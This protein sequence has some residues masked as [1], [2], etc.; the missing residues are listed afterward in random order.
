MFRKYPLFTL[1][2]LL[3]TWI[4]A[5]SQTSPKDEIVAS[6]AKL[7]GLKTYRVKITMVPGPQMEQQMQVAKQMGWDINMKPMVKEVVNPD[8]QRTTMQIMYPSMDLNMS[9]KSPKDTNG[10][11]F[12]MLYPNFV[13]VL[14]G[15]KAAS[16]IDCPECEKRMDE[17]QAEMLKQQAQ[18]MA[19]TMTMDLVRSAAEAAFMGNPIDLIRTIMTTAEQ[20]ATMAQAKKG[21]AKG[22]KELGLNQWKCIDRESDR[23]GAQPELP[24]MKNLTALPDETVGSETAKVYQFTIV[25]EK[26]NREMPIKYYASAKTGLPMKMSMTQPEGS[27]TME[28]SDFDAPIKIDIPDCMK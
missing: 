9:G 2:C 12:V 10:S 14:Q 22:K 18:Q 17:Q 3:I 1:I 27:V 24:P 13:G 16:M 11:G 25:E 4:P 5:F 8:L 19:K 23:T 26:E 6:L 15:N 20:G 21:M 7:N 28:Y